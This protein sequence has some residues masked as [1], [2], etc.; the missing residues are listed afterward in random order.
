MSLWGGGE[1]EIIH[2]MKTRA[3]YRRLVSCP[4]RGGVPPRGRHREDIAVAFRAGVHNSR[5]IT[6]T[7]TTTSSTIST[8]HS[9]SRRFAGPSGRGDAA[10]CLGGS[11]EMMGWPV[12]GGTCDDGRPTDA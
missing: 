5:K 8:A 12:G 9:P 7:A 1:V 3:R 2:A 4:Y 6:T 11:D 10:A